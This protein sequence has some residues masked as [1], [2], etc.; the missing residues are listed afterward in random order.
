MRN[1]QGCGCAVH[2]ASK[3]RAKNVTGNGQPI[4]NPFDK[5][6]QVAVAP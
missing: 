4:V 2:K 6:C 5:N 3:L 1:Y